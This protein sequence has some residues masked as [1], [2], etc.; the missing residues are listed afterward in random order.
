MNTEKKFK[1]CEFVEND[2]KIEKCSITQNGKTKKILS[3]CK[4]VG[5]GYGDS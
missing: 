5:D 4:V 1:M 3:R 2:K